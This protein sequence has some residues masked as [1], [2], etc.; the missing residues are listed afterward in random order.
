MFYLKKH[1]MDF[2]Q[3]RYYQFTLKLAEFRFRLVTQ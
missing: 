3:K 2:D 1:E